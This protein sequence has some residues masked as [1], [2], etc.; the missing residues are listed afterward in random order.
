MLLKFQGRQTFL[1][2]R[3]IPIVSGMLL[4]AS[5]CLAIDVSIEAVSESSLVLE[6]SSQNKTVLPATISDFLKGNPKQDWLYAQDP[7]FRTSYQT[8]QENV[9]DLQSFFKSYTYLVL[10]SDG[11][12][13]HSFDKLVTCLDEDGFE[14]V[15]CVVFKHD[16]NSNKAFWSYQSNTFPLEWFRLIDM[17]LNE[18]DSVLFFLRDTRACEDNFPTACARLLHLK[19]H[20]MNKKREHWHIRKRIGAGSGLFRYIHSPDNPTSMIREWGVALNENQRQQL[21]IDGLQGQTIS[22]TDLAEVKE[23]IYKH[24]EPHDLNY[25][26]TKQR[27][28]SYAETLPSHLKEEFLV[29]VNDD[30]KHWQEFLDFVKQNQL[31]IPEWDLITLCGN[32]STPGLPIRPMSE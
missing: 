12:A 15:S 32:R 23:Q 10:M 21:L 31:E 18:K 28:S 19:G 9:P 3:L 24:V 25:L 17:L 5:T 30:K 13:A 20:A 27:L 22:Q 11:I 7:F 16:K 29:F 2:S 6:A 1:F 26:K 14:I 8:F 4:I